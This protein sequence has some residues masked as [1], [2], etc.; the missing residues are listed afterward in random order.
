MK[1]VNKPII[2]RYVKQSGGYKAFTPF[3]FPPVELLAVSPWLY[4]THEEV[5]RLIG[6]LDG[7][8][9]P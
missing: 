7:I 3:S 8:K 5:T 2:C 1:D 9:N 4:K 6:K